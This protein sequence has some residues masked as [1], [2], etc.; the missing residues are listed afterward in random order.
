MLHACVV[1]L[2][3]GTLCPRWSKKRD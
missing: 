2:M 3:L 1:R